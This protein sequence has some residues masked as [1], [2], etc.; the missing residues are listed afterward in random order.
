MEVKMATKKTETNEEV[1]ETKTTKPKE[2]KKP[3]ET[4]EETPK[5]EEKK[6]EQTYTPA[7]YFSMVKDRIHEETPEN[8]RNL[9]DTCMKKLKK[10]MITGQKVAAKELYAIGT[11]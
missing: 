1:K 5:E 9:Y 2:T 6:E 4:V 11:H 8:I 3:E 10:Y 7:E